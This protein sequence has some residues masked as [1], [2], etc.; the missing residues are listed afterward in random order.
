[1]VLKKTVKGKERKRKE[2]FIKAGEEKERKRKAFIKAGEK[3]KEKKRK[4]A[5]IK[6]GE[7]IKQDI[8]ELYPE[9]Y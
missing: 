2:D 7:K 5:F 3:K 9:L 4:E 8:V 6:A 1:M